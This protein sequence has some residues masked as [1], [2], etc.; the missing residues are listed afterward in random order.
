[1]EIAD[2]IG[3]NRKDFRKQVANDPRFKDEVYSRGYVDGGISL[4][5]CN[6]MRVVT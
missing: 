4:D 5:I 6:P 2:E 1:M 3:M